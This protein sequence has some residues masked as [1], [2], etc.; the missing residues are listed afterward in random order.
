MGGNY[1]VQR[2]YIRGGGWSIFKSYDV[3]SCE[4]IS[5]PY[6]DSATAVRTADA[7]NRRGVTR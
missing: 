4:Y 2:D 5:G 6:R 7:M 1:F 3:L